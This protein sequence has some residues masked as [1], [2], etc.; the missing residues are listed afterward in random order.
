MGLVMKQMRPLE[1]LFQSRTPH[2]RFI[3]GHVSYQGVCVK[4][5]NILLPRCN[6]STETLPQEET[7]KVSLF[8]ENRRTMIAKPL[9]EDIETTVFAK[10]IYK[11]STNLRK[12]H[13]S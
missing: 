8:N 7:E 13:H 4:D 11:P 2:T 10:D 3:G 5:E 9:A 1:P 6:H 12:Y